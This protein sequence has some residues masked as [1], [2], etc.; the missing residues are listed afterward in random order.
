MEQFI[1]VFYQK[2]HWIW[3]FIRLKVLLSEY[4]FEVLRIDNTSLSTSLD[5][6]CNL[7]YVLK[8]RV[9]NAGAKILFDDELRWKKKVQQNLN[10]LVSM[11]HL[12]PYLTSFSIV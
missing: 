3:I 1:E 2:A 4:I 6:L 7:G 11:T 10:M 8:K 9:I 5:Q 12:Y